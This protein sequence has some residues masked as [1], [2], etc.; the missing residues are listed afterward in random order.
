MCGEWR[1]VSS[2]LQMLLRHFDMVSVAMVTSDVPLRQK[3]RI[4]EQFKGGEVQVR[5]GNMQVR[6]HLMAVSL[7]R[8]WCV[9]THW[10]EAWM[11]QSV[12]VW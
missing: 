8:C 4:L 3:N 10:R 7:L 12:I 2:R 6:V 11:C 9:Q 5:R 1:I